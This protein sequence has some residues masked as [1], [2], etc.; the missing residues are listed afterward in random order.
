MHW[1]STL[2]LIIAFVLAFMTGRTLR[3]TNR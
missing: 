1:P 2:A 3:K